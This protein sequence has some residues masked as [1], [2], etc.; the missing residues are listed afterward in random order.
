MGEEPTEVFELTLIETRSVSVQ[1]GRRRVYEFISSKPLVEGG[2]YTPDPPIEDVPFF[3]VHCVR[4][5]SID[6]SV[7]D[8][9]EECD[10]HKLS[11]PL[12]VV[13]FNESIALLFTPD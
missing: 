7:F 4:P 11:G 9:V 2:S 5:A 10:E 13:W 3:K 12:A 6:T 1:G 8:L